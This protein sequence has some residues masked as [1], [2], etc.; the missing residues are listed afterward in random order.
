MSHNPGMRNFPRPSTS[1][2]PRGTVTLVPTPA[3]RVPRMTTVWPGTRR[4]R[5]TSI[6]VTPVIATGVVSRAAGEMRWAVTFQRTAAAVAGVAA[7]ESPVWGSRDRVA[8]TLEPAISAAA[9][10]AT[11]PWRP[12]A[13]GDMRDTS[14]RNDDGPAPS[15]VLLEAA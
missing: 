2:A 5:A 9:N 4:P 3:T 6:T 14:V 10:A 7:A 12:T 11:S 8:R 13:A 15:T 1:R